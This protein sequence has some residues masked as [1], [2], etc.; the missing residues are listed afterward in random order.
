MYLST[1]RMVGSRIGHLKS[2]RTWKCTALCL[3]QRSDKWR[4]RVQMPTKVFALP[5]HPY[6]HKSRI[7]FCNEPDLWA[8][9]WSDCNFQ[10]CLGWINH[11]IHR[12]Y[13]QLTSTSSSI[14]FCKSSRGSL[15]RELVRCSHY[16]VTRG[17]FSSSVRHWWILRKP[18]RVGQLWTTSDFWMLG[19]WVALTHLRS[20]RRACS[21]HIWICQSR[22]SRWRC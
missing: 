14:L 17:W 15:H 3:L 18:C 20:R 9:L 2:Q 5:H 21:W 6:F 7:P 13:L 1:H 11:G 8:L 16:W 19:Y 4:N 12:N 10:V 22:S